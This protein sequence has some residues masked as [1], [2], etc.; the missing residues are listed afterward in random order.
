MRI[1]WKLDE[2]NVSG[3][4]LGRAEKPFLIVIPRGFSPEESAFPRWEDLLCKLF[5]RAVKRRPQDIRAEDAHASE[6][7]NS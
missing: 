6:A 5:S 2:R 7:R 1:Q 3:H 4:D